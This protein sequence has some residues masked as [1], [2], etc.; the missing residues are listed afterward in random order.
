MYHLYIKIKLKMLTL[1]MSLKV[2]LSLRDNFV[3]NK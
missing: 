1:V 3:Q 2:P